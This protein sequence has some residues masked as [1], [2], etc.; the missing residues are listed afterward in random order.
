[1]V[2]AAQQRAEALGVSNVRF[3]QVDAQSIDVDAATLDGVLCRWGYMLMPDGEAA[4]RDTRR[5]LKPGARVALAAWAGA[6][7]NPWSSLIGRE[8]VARGWAEPPQ[9]GTPGQFA[10]AKEGV[11][12]EML[13]AAGFTDYEIRSVAFTMSHP[14]V[15]AWLDVT[16]D[17]SRNFAGAV[18]GRSPDEIAD[19]REALRRAA[20]PHTDPDGALAFPARTW[21]AWAAA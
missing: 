17:M 13:Q 14:S 6:P 4:L 2:S 5:V 8:L 19:L 9:P 11:I 12:E 18:S 15:D 20:G 21:V 3:R 10:W 7:E 16:G 1:M